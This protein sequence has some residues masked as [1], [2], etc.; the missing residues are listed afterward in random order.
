MKGRTRVF[1]SLGV[2][3]AVGAAVAAWILSAVGAEPLSVPFGGERYELLA[4]RWLALVGVTPILA[5]G[6]G[7]SLADL[8]RL[9]RWTGVL[10]R[11]LVIGALALALA[12]PARTTD[13]TLVSTDRKSVV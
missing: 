12:R 4:P 10:V 8:P 9:Q 1:V 13:A 11:G 7:L 6:L 2:A 5:W 3:L